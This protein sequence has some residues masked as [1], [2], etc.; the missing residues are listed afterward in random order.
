MSKN[1]L[2]YLTEEVK[3]SVLEKFEGN[4]WPN[5]N[6]LDLSQNKIHSLP[7]FICRCHNLNKLTLDDNELV[8]LPND[9][10][11]MEGLA[12]LSMKK[13]QFE[14]VPGTLID[15]PNIRQ[16]DMTENKVG[17]IPEEINTN[18]KFKKLVLKNNPIRN[19]D[20]VDE[21]KTVIINDETPKEANKRIKKFLD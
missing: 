20:K 18:A 10:G 11:E 13:N 8:N 19:M 21:H 1:S 14:E 15:L 5:L 4:I 2:S 6:L 7:K 17:E 16:I 3:T 12:V 9:F